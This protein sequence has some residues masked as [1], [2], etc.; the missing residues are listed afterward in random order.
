MGANKALAGI[1]L[2]SNV[3]VENRHFFFTRH[4]KFT[5]FSLNDRSIFPV[6]IC[7]YAT[8]LSYTIRY[9]DQNAVKLALSEISRHLWQYMM[10]ELWDQRVAPQHAWTISSLWLLK[11]EAVI[12]SSQ[13]V[14]HLPKPSLDAFVTSGLLPRIKIFSFKK[15]I[16]KC[17]LQN[18]NLNKK[19]TRQPNF[20]TSTL[21]LTH[22]SRDKLPAFEMHFVERNH[23]VGSDSGS[24]RN[25]PQAIIGSKPA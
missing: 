13:S 11:Y 20:F 1:P 17:S 16:W 22:W 21:C 18:D 4:V 8:L 5:S 14:A 10:R 23:H 9:F 24:A 2:S 7:T 3:L 6:K 12:T 19:N 25:R 15:W